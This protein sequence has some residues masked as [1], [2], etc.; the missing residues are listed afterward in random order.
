MPPFVDLVSN[1]VQENIRKLNEAGVHY[2]FR[3]HLLFATIKLFPFSIVCNL[4]VN[5]KFQ[6]GTSFLAI[7]IC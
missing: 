3:K 1:D 2:P 7:P 5:I 4:E 6:R